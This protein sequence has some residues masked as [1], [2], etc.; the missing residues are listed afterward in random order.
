MNRIRAIIAASA[1]ALGAGLALAA[2]AQATEGTDPKPV[3][4]TFVLRSATGEY[5][6]V[7]FGPAPAG[8]SVVNAH[9]VELKKPAAPAVQPGVE[10]AAKDLAIGPTEITVEY[11]LTDGALPAAGAVRMFG[12]NSKNA[13]TLLDAPTWQAV[14]DTDHGTLSFTVPAGSTLGTL[15]FAYDAS[16]ESAGLVTFRNAKAGNAPISF[17]KCEVPASPTPTAK[18]PTQKPTS[19]PA[20]AGPQKTLPKTGPRSAI[21]GGGAGAL[22]LLGLAL[23]FLAR[24]R[25]KPTFRAG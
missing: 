22:V 23:Y 20:V 12:Y 11:E 16:N 14:A 6:N 17:T 18:P 2:P 5:P 21:L 9:K 24:E 15:G 10:F 3:C 13:N 7:N 19:P 25:R 8:S 1:L 4:G